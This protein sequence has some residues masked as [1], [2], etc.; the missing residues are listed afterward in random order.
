MGV[1]RSVGTIMFTKT[2]EYAMEYSHTAS[3]AC[4]SIEG[5]AFQSVCCDVTSL[6]LPSYI[7]PWYTASATPNFK[8]VVVV[9]KNNKFTNAQDHSTL[10]KAANILI[11]TLN[12]RDR[13]GLGTSLAELGLDW[14]RV[15]LRTGRSGNESVL[16]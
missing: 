12:P 10:L 6:P 16:G 5:H 1:K 3:I 2:C 15:S 4:C 7:R 14:E 11:N 13:V 9:V 8:D